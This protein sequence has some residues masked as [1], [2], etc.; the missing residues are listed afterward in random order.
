MQEE[1]LMESNSYWGVPASCV[2]TSGKS[3]DRNSTACLF[4]NVLKTRSGAVG[5]NQ[6]RLEIIL[7][8]FVFL[9]H[10]DFVIL[11]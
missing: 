4:A 6:P 11:I 2:A 3:T 8:H 7:Y 5:A 1:S 9:L 10:K